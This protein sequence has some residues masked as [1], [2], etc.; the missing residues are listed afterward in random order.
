MTAVTGGVGVAL[1]IAPVDHSLV[2]AEEDRDRFAAVRGDHLLQPGQGVPLKIV[3]QNDGAACGKD[4]PCGVVKAFERG[5]I[6]LC[7]LVVTLKTDRI[8]KN[9]FNGILAQQGNVQPL[10]KVGR[11]TGFTRRGQTR[12]QNQIHCNASVSSAS[13]RR[14]PS[15]TASS[16]SLAVSIR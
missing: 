15:G 5:M 6:Q 2:A 7:L 1:D 13:R 11:K 10:L 4:L 3:L 14:T 12:D 8:E 16:C 9:F